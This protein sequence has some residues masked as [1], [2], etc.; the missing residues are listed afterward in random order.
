MIKDLRPYLFFCLVGYCS[1]SVLYAQIWM[2]LLANKDVRTV[3]RDQNPGAASAFL[4][5]GLLCG[6]L[7]LAGDLL[8]GIFPVRCALTYCSMNHPGFLLVLLGPV[9]GH[10]WPL[11]AR[12]RG[13]KA[14]AVSFG[15]LLGLW[16]VCPAPAIVLAFFY[17]FYSVV[18]RVSPHAWRTILTFCCAFAVDLLIA[19]PPGVLLGF[20]G[21]TIVVC[22]KHLKDLSSSPEPARVELFYHHPK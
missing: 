21:T 13:G 2:R 12:F 10:A 15:V 7:S 17:L 3:Q 5:G 20:L 16:P 14:I 4:G 6:I 18:V 1:G 8:K 11:F 22:G 9:I 19:P